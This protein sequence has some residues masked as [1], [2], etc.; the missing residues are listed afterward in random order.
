MKDFQNYIRDYIKNFYEELINNINKKLNK[1]EA[2]E[3]FSQKVD[4][5]IVQKMFNSK[6]SSIEL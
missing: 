4:I 3:I 1:D 2:N 6:A 5:N